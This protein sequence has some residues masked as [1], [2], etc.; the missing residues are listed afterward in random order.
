MAH[1]RRRRLPRSVAREARTAALPSRRRSRAIAWLH[2]PAGSPARARVLSRRSSVPSSPPRH[3]ELR[4]EHCR[5]ETA[6]R[7]FAEQPQV[8]HF[9]LLRDR[10]RDRN[11]EA[12]CVAAEEQPDGPADT[13]HL[14]LTLQRG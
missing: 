10:E 12:E 9:V 3:D 14:E 2:R 8:P 11:V 5:R 4:T 7:A 6:G 1:A 13:A